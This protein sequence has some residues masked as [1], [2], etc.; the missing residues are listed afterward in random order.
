MPNL[1]IEQ[2]LYGG[3]DTGGY[4]FLARSPEFLE[5][6]LPEAQRLCT[7]FGEPLPGMGLSTAV[8]AQPFGRH[9]VA[10]VQVA[11]QGSDDAGRPVALAFH[12]LI[13]VSLG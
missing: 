8:F 2:A 12:L 1:T 6:W 7:G 5:E 10:V 9:H 3:H 11:D 4:R 13:L